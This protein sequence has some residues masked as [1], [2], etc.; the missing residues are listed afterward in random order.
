[1]KALFMKKKPADMMDGSHAKDTCRGKAAHNLWLS[2]F[3][4]EL[5]GKPR[6]RVTEDDF[7]RKPHPSLLND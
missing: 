7:E 1:M 4:L 5:A 3:A 6:N 2:P